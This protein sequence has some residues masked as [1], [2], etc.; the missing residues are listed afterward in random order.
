MRIGRKNKNEITPRNRKRKG[1]IAEY[2]PDYFLS[3]MDNW[4]DQIRNDFEQ[5]FWN[6]GGRY[7]E[8]TEWSRAPAV[9]V[10]DHGDKYE[11][12]VELPGINKEDIN[13]EITP[14]GIE[15]SANH[16]E[17]TDEKG[18]NW[19]RKERTTSSF[20]RCFDLP[21][22]LNTDDVNAEMQDGVLTVTLPKKKPTPKQKSTKV[23]IK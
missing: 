12:N 2:R 13:L 14:Y 8:L 21:E 22:E 7:Q 17:S 23:K 15:L 9:D 11:M 4:F 16:E 5:L 18:K 3:E 19:L 20:Y 1:D 6:P 10:V